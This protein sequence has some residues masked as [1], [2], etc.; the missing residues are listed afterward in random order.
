MIKF[1]IY[2][3]SISFSLFATTFEIRFIGGCSSQPFLIQKIDFNDGAN[4]G[5]LSLKVLEDN[6]VPYKGTSQ[7]INQ[8][9]NS[10]IGFEA[11]EILN[12]HEM[13]SYGWCYEIDNVIPEVYPNELVI[14][15]STQVITWFYGYGHYLNSK[16]ISQCEKSY[17]R[18][19]PQICSDLS[20]WKE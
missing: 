7:G 13:L 18:Q 20:M 17:L 3:F 14:T 1:T 19:S 10:P 4:V 9:F 11:L 6:R 12:D 5:D 15:K 8:I 2:V 16:W